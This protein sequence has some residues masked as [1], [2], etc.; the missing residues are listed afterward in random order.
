MDYEDPSKAQ[1]LKD[2]SMKFLNKPDFPKDNGTCNSGSTY[3]VML[4]EKTTNHR[5]SSAQYN[6]INRD[7]PKKKKMMPKCKITRGL[8]LAIFFSIFVCLIIIWFFFSADLNDEEFESYG[9]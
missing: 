8:F 6:Y 2:E 7:E 3:S 9:K 4:S 5:P 1:R